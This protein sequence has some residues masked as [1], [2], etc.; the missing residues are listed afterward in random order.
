[1]R[2]S[3]VPSAADDGARFRIALPENTP[4]KANA[5]S[6]MKA[7]Q[8]LFMH[9]LKHLQLQH[10]QQLKQQHIDRL[11]SSFSELSLLRSSNETSY[12]VNEAEIGR[13]HV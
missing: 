2:L 12:D 10:L 8:H 1:M 13:A 9:G 6:K 5:A 3:L 11:L 4:I 7:L